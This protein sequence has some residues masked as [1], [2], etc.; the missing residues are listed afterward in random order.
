MQSQVGWFQFGLD[1]YDMIIQIWS[2]KIG[3]FRF[4]LFLYFFNLKGFKSA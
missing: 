2:A 3:Q 1:E 4:V